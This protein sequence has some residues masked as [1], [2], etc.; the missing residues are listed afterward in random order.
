MRPIHVLHVID[1]L[2]VGGAEIAL[3]DLVQGLLQSGRY[4][5]SVCYSTPGPLLAE[6]VALGP[7]TYRLPRLARVDPLLLLRMC[8]AIRRDPPHIVHTHLF[9]SDFHGR[10][11]A[12]LCRVPVVVST[13]QNC[14]DW[15]NNPLLGRI[16]GFTARFADGLIAVSNEVRDFAISRTHVA[17]DKLCVIPNSVA[18]QR[19]AHQEEA[20]R[21]ARREFGIDPGAPLLGIIARLAPQKDHQTFLE[22]AARIHSAL[23]EARFLIVGDGP[24][25]ETLVR[26]AGELGVDQAVI[27]CGVRSDIPAIMA[28]LDLLVLSSRWEGLPVALVE[29][30]A[31]ARPVVATAVGGVP[32]VVL[33]GSTGLLVPPADPE[34]LADAC[35][36]ALTDPD[37]RARL[38]RAGRARAEAHFSLDAMVRQTSQLYEELLSSRLPKS[39]RLRKSA[40]S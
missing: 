21:G 26:R 15:A 40:V 17:P 32:E 11:A 20:G 27:F 9:K 39:Q 36:Q 37:L 16:Y 7:P 1:G 18:L 35:I 13:L 30:M 23:P 14:D 5:V 8:Q 25:R 4:R 19:F 6:M 24:L 31:A 38:G 28:A 2:N 3:R 22:A 12:R 33:H 29:G 34:A 10:I